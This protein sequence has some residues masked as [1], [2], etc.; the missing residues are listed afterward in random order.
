M[1]ITLP[2]L[3]RPASADAFIQRTGSRE[4]PGSARK[5]VSFTESAWGDPVRPRSRHCAD[6]MGT[7][8]EMRIRLSSCSFKQGVHGLP[9][10]I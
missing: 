1:Y 8:P 2:I 5:L 7:T 3:D 4:Q 9:S 6:V 10:L